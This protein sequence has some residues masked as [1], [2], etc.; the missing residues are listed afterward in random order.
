MKESGDKSTF[1]S[2]RRFHQFSF[3]QHTEM[4]SGKPKGA[5]SYQTLVDNFISHIPNVSNGWDRWAG[6]MGKGEIQ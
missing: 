4:E 2:F 6:Y 1:E 5:E 3:S